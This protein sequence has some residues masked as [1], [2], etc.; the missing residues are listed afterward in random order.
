MHL[1]FLFKDLWLKCNTL[2]AYPSKSLEHLFPFKELTPTNL[3]VLEHRALVSKYASNIAH[4]V[5]PETLLGNQSFICMYTF[6]KDLW[7]KCN[8]LRAYPSKSV[9]HLFRVLG[10]HIRPTQIFFKAKLSFISASCL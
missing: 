10:G 2:R 1:Y 8:T 9:E 7:L 6:F 4:G 3:L 5:Q